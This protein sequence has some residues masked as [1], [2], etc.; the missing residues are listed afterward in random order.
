MASILN[1]PVL[2]DASFE[3]FAEDRGVLYR[4]SFWSI[5]TAP[6]EPSNIDHFGWR[7]WEF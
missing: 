3:R 2:G 5:N 1:P 6:K 4:E 7:F